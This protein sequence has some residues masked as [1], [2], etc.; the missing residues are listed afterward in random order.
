MGKS[1]WIMY[2]YER[3]SGIEPRLVPLERGTMLPPSR[4]RQA[5]PEFYAEHD[6]DFAQ[7]AFV[8]PSIQ[9]AKPAALAEARVWRAGSCTAPSSERLL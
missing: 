5:F 4:D 7:G 1:S 2:L 6:A 8:H 3:V 9:W